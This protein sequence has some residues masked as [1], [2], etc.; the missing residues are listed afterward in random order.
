[1]SDKVI[2]VAVEGDD[3][4][5]L[6]SIGRTLTRDDCCAGVAIKW[7][8]HRSGW[9]FLYAISWFY[10]MRT[11]KNSYTSYDIIHRIF[12]CRCRYKSP[13]WYFISCLLWYFF[14]CLHMMSLSCSAADTVNPN[15]LFTECCMMVRKSCTV[16]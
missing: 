14:F 6:T 15:N 13:S 4:R 9:D 3:V 12:L 8:T 10:S 7:N 1:M 2:L 16:K 5:F 11:E